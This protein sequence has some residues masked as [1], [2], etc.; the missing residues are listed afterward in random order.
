MGRPSAVVM[1]LAM[2]LFMV[3][4]NTSSQDLRFYLTSDDLAEDKYTRYI[5]ADELRD[6]S[7]F[8]FDA[9]RCSLRRQNQTWTVDET[10][11][12][13]TCT[14]VDDGSL[15]EKR[16]RCSQPPPLDS[17]NGLDCY[18][19]RVQGRDFPDCCPKLWCDGEPV[20]FSEAK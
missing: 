13:A 14:K 8:C 3:V 1:A 16:T 20:S 11:E 17:F 15:M 4:Q 19:V 7:G 2:V 6:H 18:I 9:E 5:K 12:R 10:C